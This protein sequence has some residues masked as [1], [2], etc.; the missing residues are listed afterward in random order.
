MA[1]LRT[2]LLADLLHAAHPRGGQVAVLQHSPRPFELGLVQRPLGDGALPLP[3]AHQGRVLPQLHAELDEGGS[4]VGAFGEDEDER[5][6]AARL[7]KTQCQVEHGRGH[8]LLAFLG[9]HEVLHREHDLVWPH[10]ADAAQPLQRGHLLL[11]L[12]RQRHGVGLDA[13]V[14][15]APLPHVELEV[16]PKPVHRLQVRQA[17]HL[18][19][20]LVAQPL[21]GRVSVRVVQTNTARQQKVPLVGVQLPLPLQNLHREQKAEHQFVLLQQG[22]AHVSVQAQ[23]KV[24]V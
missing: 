24:V 4:R 7:P 21:G 6:R 11:P 13:V 23:R 15:G 20:L 1:S 22:A 17:A 10:A 5:G 19:P 9:Y 18:P 2:Q 12:P 3:Q 8:K 14:D 16:L